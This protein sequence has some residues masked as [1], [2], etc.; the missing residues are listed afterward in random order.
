MR[1][2]KTI[3][4]LVGIRRP[5]PSTRAGKIFKWTERAIVLLAGVYLLLSV[6]P[7]ILFAHSVQSNGITVYSHTPLAPGATGTVQRV[8][9]TVSR[10]ALFTDKAKPCVFICN[11]RSLYTF[12]VP[13]SRRSFAVSYPLTDNI[14][15][16][17]A[18]LGRDR[19]YRFADGHNQRSFHSLVAHEIGHVL[20][21]R[22]IG[23]LRDHRL[24]TWIKEGYC[25]YIAGEGTL[26]DEAG[27]PMLLAGQDD[28]S[29][30]LRYFVWRKL[31]EYL[32]DVEGLTFENLATFSGNR[33]AVE[34]NMIQWLSAER[35]IEQGT[36]R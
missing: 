26:S 24:P 36:S 4:R 29:M 17:H 7:E 19:A 21:R 23:R 2:S 16:A 20:I 12:F 11:S 18:D 9:T 10:S 22:R 25:E 14:F 31:V 33:E 6:F 35:H 1:L 8:H 34:S 30:A 13:F 15:V 27:I 32:I 28:D 5:K 3:L